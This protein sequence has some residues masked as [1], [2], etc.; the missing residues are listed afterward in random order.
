MNIYKELGVHP[1]VNAMGN[2]TLLGGNTPSP[3]IRIGHAHDVPIIVDRL[4]EL[5]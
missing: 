5:L 4:R 3:S 1:V 2:R